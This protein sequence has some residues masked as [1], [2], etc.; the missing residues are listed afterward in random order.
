M[1]KN[2]EI[3]QQVRN[4]S[5]DK[6]GV[7]TIS[8]D[9]RQSVYST[10][11]EVLTSIPITNRQVGLTVSIYNQ[12]KV[13]EYWF[14]KGITD[15]DLVVKTD[16][17]ELKDINDTLDS[18]QRQID[19]LNNIEYKIFEELPAKGRSNIIYLIPDPVQ[20]SG[21]LYD[22]YC[23]IE[24]QQ[25]Y[26][27]F[28][29]VN[30]QGQI[31]IQNA[32]NFNENQFKLTDDGALKTV[33][34]NNDN[35][36]INQY[37]F[38][39]EQSDENLVT[40]TLGFNQ[41]FLS[42]YYNDSNGDTGIRIDANKIQFEDCDELGLNIQYN[43]IDLISPDNT[44]IIGTKIK[45]SKIYLNSSTDEPDNN[46]EILNLMLS[47]EGV[48]GSDRNGDKTFR[49]TID[50]LVFRDE[51]YDPVNLTRNTFNLEAFQDVH[52][53]TMKF[54]SGISSHNI[55]LDT[56]N[57]NNK[58]IS[59]KEES[60]SILLK[61]DYI[62]L[63]SSSNINL[64]S[65]NINAIG[66]F[67]ISTG[68]FSTSLKTV[69]E[70]NGIYL[71]IDKP[72]ELEGDNGYNIKDGS[73][74]IVFDKNGL[75]YRKNPTGTYD[76]LFSITK[77]NLSNV[78]RVNICDD[79]IVINKNNE[80]TSIYGRKSVD[81]QTELNT[82]MMEDL[83]GGDHNYD[84]KLITDDDNLFQV[85]PTEIK[86]RAVGRG[87]NANINTLSYGNTELVANGTLKLCSGADNYNDSDAKINLINGEIELYSKNNSSYYGI[88]IDGPFQETTV[89]GDF[90][91]KSENHSSATERFNINSN[92]MFVK[93]NCQFALANR[94]TVRFTSS[95]IEFS[96]NGTTITKTWSDLLS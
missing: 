16:S 95:G 40:K 80:I 42:I 39:F 14:E 41:E 77:N 26:E 30:D 31:V 55:E 19:N 51:D 32:F 76:N 60:N 68:L 64:N 17:N 73:S 91:I 1:S 37:G 2:R 15:S 90:L 7:P 12:G 13:V 45:S 11:S 93:G 57:S 27:R 47:N 70:A 63:Q 33:S 75:R 56:D 5:V 83:P 46:D 36:S 79:S 92:G 4:T 69:T 86:L 84:I 81:I 20:T 58:Y 43:E 65:N 21:N 9:E 24:S 8:L 50:D 71:K 3:N 34:L 28:G 38:K 59:I 35:I 78:T 54:Y 61:E 72:I 44:S 52:F 48:F 89:F 82:F 62:T 94:T 87:T 67:N 88:K 96:Q 49:L 10:I 85:T 23:W 29:G 18:L 53:N 22:E 25:R 74:Y 6:N 66:D